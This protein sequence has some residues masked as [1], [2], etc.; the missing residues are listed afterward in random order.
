MRFPHFQ[1]LSLYRVV[2]LAWST[3][4]SPN[5]PGGCWYCGDRSHHDTPCPQRVRDAYRFAVA[6]TQLYPPRPTAAVRVPDILWAL[7]L[8]EDLMVMAAADL[9]A[10]Q[11]YGQTPAARGAELAGAAATIG[12]WARQIELGRGGQ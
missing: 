2:P 5:P 6:G 9:A 1:R 7:R 3:N 11:G 8:L 12:E 10:L 4:T